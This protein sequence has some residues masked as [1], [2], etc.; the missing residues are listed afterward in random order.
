MEEAFNVDVYKSTK[1][2]FLELIVL[3]VILELTVV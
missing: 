3:A 1:L 2:L